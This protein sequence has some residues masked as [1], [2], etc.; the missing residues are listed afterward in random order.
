MKPDELKA[1]PLVSLEE[2]AHGERQ[3][4]DDAIASI[5][6][7]QAEIDRRVHVIDVDKQLA[8]MHPDKKALL[9]EALTKPSTQVLQVEG[10]VESL[11]M[12]ELNQG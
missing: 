10:I 8:S 11:G 1:L 7:V 9:L 3:R 2:I 4:R 12:G 5:L 6:M